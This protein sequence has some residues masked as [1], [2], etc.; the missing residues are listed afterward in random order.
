M[1]P[2][3]VMSLFELSVMISSTQ[4]PGPPAKEWQRIA[5]RVTNMASPGSGDLGEAKWMPAASR[6]HQSG[7]PVIAAPT[8][9]PVATLR[10]VAFRREIG[11]QP[12]RMGSTS[13]RGEPKCQLQMAAILDFFPCSWL[14][15]GLD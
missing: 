2:W 9:T 8:A 7:G 15:R 12:R 11:V 3:K 10:D 14:R 4:L 13:S 6:E 5:I 1:Q